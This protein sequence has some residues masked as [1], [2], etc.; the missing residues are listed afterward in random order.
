M[1]QRTVQ[2]SEWCWRL[3]FIAWTPLVRGTRSQL[4]LGSFP[5]RHLQGLLGDTQGLWE[6]TSVLRRGDQSHV[7]TL[8]L[9]TLRLCLG[10]KLPSKYKVVLGPQQFSHRL[11]LPGGQHST[12]F[13]VEGLAFPDAD[14]KG[15]ISLTVS[16]LDKSNPVGLGLGRWDGG[17]EAGIAPC[18]T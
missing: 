14:F 6:G 17:G 2:S 9:S 11:E 5:P 18:L 13:Y 3:Q 4:E 8:G 10:G 12:D 1:N 7:G 15:L 16:L